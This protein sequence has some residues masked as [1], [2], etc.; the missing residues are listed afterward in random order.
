VLE[1]LAPILSYR[2]DEGGL[3]FRR[4]QLL[5]L[6]RCE[7]DGARDELVSVHARRVARVAGGAT[8]IAGAGCIT[9]LSG[10]TYGARALLDA[11]LFANEP[12]IT[13]I[14][15]ATVLLVPVAM[16]I[17]WSAARRRM[18]TAMDGAVQ[19][20]SDIRHDVARLEHAPPLALLTARVDSLEFH[21]VWVPLVGWA[22]VAPLSMHLMLALAL[23]W[24]GI[25]QL[26][27]FDW[28]ILVSL[29][30]TGVGHGVLCMMAVRFARRLRAWNPTPTSTESV[31]SVWS[32]YGWTL[33]GACVPGVILYAV[34]PLIAAVTSLF[35]PVTF[36]ALRRRV[37]AE[38]AA[39]A[40]LVV[41]RDGAGA[42][43]G[44]R[45]SLHRRG[46]IAAYARD[47]D[48]S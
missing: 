3:R 14:L 40:S 16:A 23:G 38:R 9:F 2:D 25:G 20:M 34:P 17:A 42:P 27:Q 47:L 35:I 11:P 26:E 30:L 6:R 31:P 12:P 4:E 45:W 15:V 32:P 46:Q 18:E 33:L 10:L 41:R 13:S 37:L 48:M 36:L 7:V 21:S 24:V 39:L 44:S 28:W 22:L 19:P 5:V 1:G 8:A 43:H 29:V